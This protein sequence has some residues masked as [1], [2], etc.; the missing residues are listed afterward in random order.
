MQYTMC[1]FQLGSIDTDTTTKDYCLA[2]D[3]QQLL[4]LNAFSRDSL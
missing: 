4:V 1:L 3:L 2:N